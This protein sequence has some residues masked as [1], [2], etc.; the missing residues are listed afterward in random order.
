ML[1][2]KVIND[3]GEL[4]V[5]TAIKYVSLYIDDDSKVE[6]LVENCRKTTTEDSCDR[7]LEMYLCFDFYTQNEKLF[8]I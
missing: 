2:L 5:P 4:L 3:K 8:G 6:D 1:R 7:S